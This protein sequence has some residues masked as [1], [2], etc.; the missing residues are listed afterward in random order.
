MISLRR[1]IAFFTV[2]FVL[3][4][5]QFSAYATADGSILISL[6]D[7]GVPISGAEIKLYPVGTP[8]QTGYRLT[9]TFGGGMITQMD[10]YSPE[11]A[12]WLA[13]G[14]SGGAQQTTDE[15]GRAGFSQLEEGLYLV[16]QE[17]AGNGCGLFAPFLVV[18]PWD[19]DQW[20]IT[21]EPKM[22]REITISPETA[23]PGTV[24][25]AFWGMVTSGIGLIS[26]AAAKKG[27]RS[28][29]VSKGSVM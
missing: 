25:W 9:E 18:I 21:L 14:A 23:D 15:E 20:D 8:T 16:T 27:W 4:S 6:R 2:M 28:R 19:G 17:S 24:D 11:L 12:A 7:E 5:M 29:I 26:M 13:Q 1:I 22:D 10:V 3:S